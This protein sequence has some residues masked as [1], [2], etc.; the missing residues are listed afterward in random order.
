MKE[1]LSGVIADK[2]YYSSGYSK[3]NATWCTAKVSKFKETDK[4]YIC[5]GKITIGKDDD[6]DGDSWKNSFDFKDML[7]KKEW[8]EG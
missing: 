5:S 3:I 6:G 4:G 8:L 7:V 2:Y 1:K